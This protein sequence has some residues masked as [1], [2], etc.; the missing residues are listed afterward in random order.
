MIVR[1]GEGAE[2]DTI[3]S[4]FTDGLVGFD[5]MVREPGAE[6]E[7][8]GE[9]LGFGPG[10]LIIQTHRPPVSVRVYPPEYN[11]DTDVIVV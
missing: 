5:V 3:R 2:F 8:F 6:L 11:E 10:G 9:V 4:V 7:V 1:F